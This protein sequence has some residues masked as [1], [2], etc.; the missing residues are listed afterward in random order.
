[1]YLWCLRCIP[2]RCKHP[3]ME[4][5]TPVVDGDYVAFRVR[6]ELKRKRKSVRKLA[7]ELGVTPSYMQRRVSG[8][9]P[10]R[11][12]EIQEVADLLGVEVAAF[13]PPPQMQARAS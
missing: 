12:D 4:T 13:F 11:T 8:R 5:Q 2:Q 1:M 9:V 7:R 10:F 3:G 6:H